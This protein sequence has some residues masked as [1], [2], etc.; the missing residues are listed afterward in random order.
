MRYLLLGLISMLSFNIQSIENKVQFVS[1]VKEF[2]PYSIEVPQTEGFLQVSEKH[3]LYF[4]TYGNPN[5][6]PV[7]ILHG[8]P[9]IGCSDEYTRFFDLNNW[10]VIM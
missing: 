1:T 5:G 4:A 7:V 3:Q 6:I 8:G 10:H 2:V 9:G